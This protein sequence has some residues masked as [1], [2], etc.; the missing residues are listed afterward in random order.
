MKLIIRLQSNVNT[1]LTNHSLDG[2]RFHNHVVFYL[3]L[4]KKI[5]QNRFNLFKTALV[6]KLNRCC[7]EFEDV[8]IKQVKHHAY[9]GAKTI[10][11]KNQ[12]WALNAASEEYMLELV[13]KYIVDILRLNCTLSNYEGIGEKAFIIAD[14]DDNMFEYILN[15][16]K[17]G[18]I[19]DA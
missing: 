13:L 7:P 5:E 16:Y 6:N 4:H 2:K 11:L 15:T 9:D 3:N 1:L 12:L 17:N 10:N 14:T 19:I 8:S 18:V